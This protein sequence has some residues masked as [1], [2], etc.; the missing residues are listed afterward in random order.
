MHR[1]A[2]ILLWESEISA[3]KARVGN[4]RL[5]VFRPFFHLNCFLFWVKWQLALRKLVSEG[6]R[7]TDTAS[8]LEVLQPR[9]WSESWRTAWLHC[10]REETPWAGAEQEEHL[11]SWVTRH[12]F[13]FVPFQFPSSPLSSDPGLARYST[14]EDIKCSSVVMEALTVFPALEVLVFQSTAGKAIHALWS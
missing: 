2:R 6:R 1:L 12:M 5:V 11:A 7:S 9:A 8:P 10:Q 4:S 3:E 14:Q 13:S